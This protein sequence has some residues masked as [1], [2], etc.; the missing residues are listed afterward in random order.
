MHPSTFATKHPYRFTALL[1]AAVTLA[2]LAA[3]TAAALLSLPASNTSDV[4]LLANLALAVLGAALLTGLRWWRH[5]GFR[6]LAA[7]RDLRLYWLPFTLVLVNLASGVAFGFARMDIGRV[8]Y[9]LAMAGLIG[10]VE[11]VFF[12]GLI[13]RALAPRGLWRAAIVSSVLFG[14]AHSLNVLSGA[15]PLATLLQVG[16][17]LA[18]GFGFAAVTL[19]TGTIWPL[20]LIHALIDFASFRVTNG[21][22]SGSATTMDMAITALY[23]VAF[24]GYGIVMLRAERRPLTRAGQRPLALSE[25]AS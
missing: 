5:V 10:F 2:Y 7:P 20:V 1:V 4:Y 25:A 13:L 22:S 17:A 18:I 3:G 11:E 23:I 9:F 14:L 19:R 12:R 15:N 16:Y 24:T 6:A 8:A 21:V